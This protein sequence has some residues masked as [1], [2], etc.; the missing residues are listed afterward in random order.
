MA[1]ARGS[2]HELHAGAALPAGLCALLADLAGSIS[3]A[4]TAE[5]LAAL[6]PIARAQPD[7][8]HSCWAGVRAVLL[9]SLDAC[10]TAG[11]APGAA[12]LALLE[13]GD[14]SLGAVN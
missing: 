14:A 3:A 8:L 5:A 1:W 4:V 11:D 10:G 13:T 2:Q 12:T 6:Q 9:Q 7:A